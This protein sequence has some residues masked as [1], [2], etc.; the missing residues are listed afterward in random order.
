MLETLDFEVP[1]TPEQVAKALKEQTFFRPMPSGG[2]GPV[3]WSQKPL[4]GRVGSDA[5]TV[6]LYKPSFLNLT[7]SVARAKLIATPSG[8]RVLGQ[9]GLHPWVTNYLRF[10]FILTVL[11]AL[12]LGGIVLTDGGALS[13][14]LVLSLFVLLTTT[15]AIGANVAHAD[16]KIE[17]LRQVLSRTLASAAAPQDESL[18]IPDDPALRVAEAEVESLESPGPKSVPEG[19]I[20]S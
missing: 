17:E 11:G 15:L 6:S 1:G 3:R 20:G 18:A 9:V 13:I 2:A 7:Q 14:W 19:P 8:T 12:G 4:G 5:F 16:E 10:A